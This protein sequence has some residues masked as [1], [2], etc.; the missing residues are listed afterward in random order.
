M[1]TP[2][3]SL[4]PYLWLLPFLGFL[5]GYQLLY[6]L[7]PKTVMPA[8]NLVGEPLATA[9]KTLATQQLNLRVSAEQT[10]PGLPDQVIISQ[11]P[12]AGQAIKANQTVYVV[13][14][15]QPQPATAPSLIGKTLE[16][17]P[18]E[19]AP[20]GLK[21]VTYQVPSSQPVDTC[22]AQQPEPDSTTHK[23]QVLAYLSAGTPQPVL[24]PDLRQLNLATVCEFLTQYQVPYTIVNLPAPIAD[25]AALASAHQTEISAL[26]D[27]QV[28]DQRPVAGT[29]LPQLHA[30]TVK[31]K[32]APV[33]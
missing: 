10:D 4:T 8:P 25:P 29:L 31:L 19:L 2:N 27:Y 17:L 7:Q 22:I 32:V 9:V 11:K 21:P 24:M 26:Q 33:N 3:R 14:S 12:Y 13:L 30:V 16:Q 18:A 6:F 23:N 20:L 5:L 1:T 28:I 15:R